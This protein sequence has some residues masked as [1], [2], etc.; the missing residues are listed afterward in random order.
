[1][2]IM[3]AETRRKDDKQ[4]IRRTGK[5]LAFLRMVNALCLFLTRALPEVDSEHA[6]AVCYG[7]V[8]S[9]L[10][11]ARTQTKPDTSF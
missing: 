11:N 4:E 9:T 6:I 10:H 8:L 2:S 1:M 3:R 5:H 7:V